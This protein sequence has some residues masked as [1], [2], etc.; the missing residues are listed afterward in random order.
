MNDNQPNFK[1][2]IMAISLSVITLFVW[3]HFM[4]PKSD[5][6]IEKIQKSDVVIPEG[7]VTPTSSNVVI[8]VEEGLK[9]APRQVLRNK[10][11]AGSINL[12]TGRFDDLTLLNHYDGY[13]ENKKN[14]RLF[15]P[16]NSELGF[17]AEMNYT[18]SGK[19][20]S[21]QEG[22]WKV[23]EGDELSDN[24]SITLERSVEDI[25]ITRKVTLD[26]HFMF[27]VEDS[28]TNNGKSTQSVTPYALLK[29][30][31]PEYLSH[32][33]SSVV[34]TGFVGWMNHQLEE[35]NFTNIKK[36]PNQQFAT[37]GGWIGLTEKYWMATLIPTKEDK[38][39]SVNLRYNPFNGQDGYQTDY[40]LQNKS[41][42]AGEVQ[43]VSY[44]LFAGAKSVN[45]I[46]KYN[47]AGI[48]GFNYSVDWGWFWFF[49][50]PMFKGLLYLHSLLGNYGLAILALTLVVKLVFYPLASKSY[51]AMSKM[52]KLQPFMEEIKAKYGDDPMKQQQELIALYRREKL[53][54]VAGCWPMLLQIPVFY[55]LYKVFNVALELRHAPF[56]LWIQDLSA[57]DPTTI[58][59]L[60]GL[61]PY[62]PSLYIP[63]FLNIGVLPILM[64]VTM[65]MQ[66]RLNP[67]S[68]DPVQARIM[69]FFPLIF[70]FVLGSFASGLVLYW[71]WNN[72]L[73]VM[74]QYLITKSMDDVVPQKPVN[75]NKKKK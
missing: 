50:R 29:M 41:L 56:Y 48:E 62:D 2:L 5:K 25:T 22:E 54:P 57:K 73:S 67:A 65:W 31:Y 3:D 15:S 21:S 10:E 40:V 8:S 23:I 49:T 14:I 64:G 70:T 24:K 20:V 4:V 26:E 60:F 71:T 55:A 66:Q 68:P 72:I 75:S 47:D 39:A 16:S 63:N 58:F 7:S 28:L 69:S 19:P 59:N 18:I 30:N 52:K 32:A 46:E 43:K 42:V 44:R 53:N 33:E 13:E 61:I 35:V 38:I 37:D 17:F 36:E 9:E 45:A 51:R 12:K 34:H 1:N 74:Q 6:K 11:I 27:T